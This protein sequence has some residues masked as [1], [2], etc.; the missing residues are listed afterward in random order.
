MLGFSRMN[1][2]FSGFSEIFREIEDFPVGIVTDE[3]QHNAQHQPFFH[4]HFPQ[5]KTDRR[6]HH[7]AFAI[8]THAIP[9]S[10]LI[11]GSIPHLSVDGHRRLSAIA[12]HPDGSHF[13]IGLVRTI[14]L[15]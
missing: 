1:L 7:D 13:P 14:L 11:G 4:F 2:G 8:I 6:Y 10:A 3:T 5:R 9:S 12:V 15:L